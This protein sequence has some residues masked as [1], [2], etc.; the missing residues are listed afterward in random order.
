MQISKA[1]W[2]LARSQG[3]E[4][5]DA[6]IATYF[7][8]DRE[9]PWR[10]EW[11]RV[12]FNGDRN[13]KAAPEPFQQFL[14]ETTQW[15][16]WADKRLFDEG[17]RFF[18]S[19]AK[20]VISVLSLYSLPY[21][22]AGADGAKVLYASEQIRKNPGRRLT[23]TGEFVL[24]VMHPRGF[25]P[26]QKGFRALQKVRLLHASIRF[27]LTKHGWDSEAYGVPINQADMAGTNAA[28]G[29]IVLKG[30]AKLGFVLGVDQKKAFLHT[31]KVLGYWMGVSEEYLTDESVEAYQLERSLAA[32][33][34]R[35]SM[36][37]QA[38]TKSLLDYMQ[39]SSPVPG[40]G[41]VAE[42]IMG[43]FMGSEVA[44]I[45]GLP[46]K[47]FPKGT[48]PLF[49]TPIRTLSARRDPI[50]GYHKAYRSLQIQR[51]V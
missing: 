16:S 23:D 7:S 49:Y 30:L 24:N 11:D 36:E 1:D 48:L 15:P 25:E 40:F 22:Y 46:S 42:R 10:A 18:G 43:A 45:L 50:Q 3:D 12:S 39:E 41:K 38:L 47:G 26:E 33:T 19:Y 44:G 2:N 27:H 28:F 35:S 13:P 21:C 29:W 34:F 31:W 5:A 4:L 17:V 14:Q 32:A 20:E 37:G 6:A 51:K 9:T 8:A